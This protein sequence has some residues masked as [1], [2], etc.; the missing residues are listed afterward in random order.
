MRYGC[1]RTMHSSSYSDQAVPS[2]D[3]DLLRLRVLGALGERDPEQSLLEGRLD[4]ALLQSR[5]HRERACERAVVALGDAV[6]GA[7]GLGGGLVRVR[8]R[9]GENVAGNPVSASSLRW[10]REGGTYSWREMSTFSFLR[11]G[12][13]TIA[14]R[15]SL[16][17][18]KS[19]RGE[20]YAVPFEYRCPSPRVLRPRLKG[21]SSKSVRRMSESN[22]K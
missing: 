14:V 19:R 15:F 20:P 2:A 11:P 1:E 9:D 6:R 5:G 18:I 3:R 10:R 21:R 16:S 22:G 7:L 4:L 8:A 12:H 13:S 17:S